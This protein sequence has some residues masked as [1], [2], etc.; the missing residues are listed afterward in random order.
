MTLEEFGAYWL[1]MSYIWLEG[2][3]VYDVER[4]A[5][6]VKTSPKKFS[7]LWRA[8]ESL[9]YVNDGKITSPELDEYR[10]K[11]QEWKDKSRLGGLRSGETRRKGGSNLVR[12]KVEPGLN[13]SPSPSSSSSSSSGEVPPTPSAAESELNGEGG[14]VSRGSKISLEER[15]QYRDAHGLGNGWLVLSE[16]GRYDYV[17][18][19]WIE[20]GKPDQRRMGMAELYDPSAEAE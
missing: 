19:E 2:Y 15:R 7:R 6:L 13:T 20:R 10:L 8:M 5:K 16:D 14:G 18:D 4:L 11:Q 3:L 17:I 9:F 12:T 1:L